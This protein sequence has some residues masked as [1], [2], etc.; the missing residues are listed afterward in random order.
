[1]LDFL[2][3]KSDLVGKLLRPL[4]A[5]V[6]EPT[7][8][9]Q[10]GMIDRQKLEG[11]S[12]RGRTRQFELAKDF[13]ITDFPSPAGGCLLTDPGFSRRLRELF[14]QKSSADLD[15]MELL[16][17]GRHFWLKNNQLVIGRDEAENLAIKS[18]QQTNDYVFKIKNFTGPIGLL[19]GKAIDQ[20][21]IKK[22]AALVAWYSTKARQES[23]VEVEVSHQN[24]VIK[25]EAKPTAE[26][27][28]QNH[29]G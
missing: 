1:M 27:V 3:R 14:K 13:K 16:K 28:E 8:A 19:R 4:S 9:E 21:L 15:D 22:S 20:A 11:I 10:S 6:L 25:I 2:E 26:I 24:E 23:L 5:Q 18:L 17:I 12:G 29:R 7:I